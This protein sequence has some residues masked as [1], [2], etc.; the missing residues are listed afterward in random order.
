MRTSVSFFL[1]KFL[2]RCALAVFCITGV[3]WIIDQNIPFAGAKRI[4][5]TFGSLHGQVSQLRPLS[6]A[7][8]LDLSKNP[9]T[10]TVFE[11]PVYFDIKTLVPYQRIIFTVLYQNHSGRQ[12][13][14]GVKDGEGWKFALKPFKEG[15]QS[16]SAKATAD[17]GEWT[18]GEV[19]FDLTKSSYAN[20]R[21]TFLFSIPGLTIDKRAYE[22]IIFSQMNITLTRDDI[23]TSVKN[24]FKKS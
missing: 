11:D 1:F 17:K 13:G 8:S 22:Y 4:A 15:I 21:Y 16:V 14:M 20:G 6:R 10:Q 23:I 24:F 19:E 3:L 5:Y 9:Q 2:W 7:T 18:V 12:I